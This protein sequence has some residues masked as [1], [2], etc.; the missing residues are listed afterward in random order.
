MLYEVITG[1]RATVHAGGGLDQI[2]RT[3]QGR[4]EII[5]NHLTRFRELDSEYHERL[6]NQV[7]QLTHR[8]HTLE[9][10]TEVLRHRVQEKQ[11]QALQDVL[12]GIANR[13]AFEEHFK[14]EQARQR[15]FGHRITSYNVCYTK[16]LR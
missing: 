11:R 12:T 3:I 4:L 5:Q 1:I 15:R 10:E 2:K 13:L 16:L 6:G 7:E 8:L 14:A 9:S